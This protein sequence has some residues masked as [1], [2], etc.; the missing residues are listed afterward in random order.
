M[1]IPPGVCL[2]DG[3]KDGLR[4]LR[5]KVNARS[6]L[7][8][9]LSEIRCFLFAAIK[10]FTGTCHYCSDVWIFQ[11]QRGH[12]DRANQALWRLDWSELLLQGNDIH[13][14]FLL[15]PH[16]KASTQISARKDRD[17]ISLG[18]KT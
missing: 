2:W 15:H 17:R 13:G 12:C 1:V 18:T 8:G 14:A 9:P 16:Q 11:E 3:G 7:V 10:A 4:D 6:C 5:R